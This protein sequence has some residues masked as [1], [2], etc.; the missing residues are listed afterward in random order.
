MSMTGS[1][2][3]AHDIE[4]ANDDGV[5]IYY[6]WTNNNTE[7]VVS[8]CG[9]DYQAYSNEYTGNVVIPE[10]VEYNGNTY[11]VTSIGFRAFSD[12]SSLTS[13]VSLTKEPFAIYGKYSDNKLFDLNIFNN[14]TLYVPAGTIDKYKATKGWKDFLFIEEGEYIAPKKGD[15]N[16]DGKVDKDDLKDLVDY[17]MGGKPNGV[18][19]EVAVHA[20][21]A[22]P[23]CEGAHGQGE[24]DLQEP[25]RRRR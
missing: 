17:I 22:A 8:Y 5:T 9:S 7:L 10:S 6:V 25:V 18:T 13:V 1:K 11:P 15:V 16:S 24:G 14:A 3:F 20:A 23:P 21:R 2:T 12:C 4:V 19:V